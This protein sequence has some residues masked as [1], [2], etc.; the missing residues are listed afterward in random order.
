LQKFASDKHS[1]LFPHSI[2]TEKKFY[3]TY[4]PGFSN[5]DIEAK[6]SK[7]LDW[8]GLTNASGSFTIKYSNIEI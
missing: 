8:I 5:Q 4:T 7:I 2:G 6:K 3:L 1:S